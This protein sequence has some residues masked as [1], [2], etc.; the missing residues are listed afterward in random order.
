MREW[1]GPCIGVIMVELT[2]ENC[3]KTFYRSRARTYRKDVPN[4]RKFCS[5]TCYIPIY[6]N[7][8]IP[9]E[10]I[11]KRN[12]PKGSSSP[13]WK[14]GKYITQ[15]GYIMVHIPDH[16]LTNSNGW[17]FE[18]T[19]IACQKENRLL[20]KGEQVHHVDGNKQNNDPGNLIVVSAS[21]HT[22]IHF[23][24][25]NNR[26]EGEPNITI[27]CNCGCG[28]TLFKYDNRGKPRRFIHGHNRNQQT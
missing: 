3:G 17:L 23:G 1:G 16:P 5:H 25:P 28:N 27:K 9:Q 8:K 18:H 15:D 6:K 12:T 26:Q 10:V 19:V 22:R 24:N 20:Q 14:G 13:H 7:K 21:T 4:K 2:C 11:A